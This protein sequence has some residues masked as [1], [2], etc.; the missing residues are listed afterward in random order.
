MIVCL[1]CGKLNPEGFNYCL[2]CGAELNPEQAHSQESN[3]LMGLSADTP[4]RVP[5]SANEPPM[6]LTPEKPVEPP[7][8]PLNEEPVELQPFDADDILEEVPS[9]ETLKETGETKSCMNCGATMGV[10]D[11]FCGGCGAPFGQKKQQDEGRTM[12]MSPLEMTNQKKPMGKLVSLDPSGQEGMVYNLGERT[13]LGRTKADIT[14]DDDIYISPLHCTME[15]KGGELHI[16]DEASTNGV[17][18][19]LTGTVPLNSRDVFRIGQQVII[20][21][22]PGDFENVERSQSNDGTVFWGAPAEN[23]WGKLMRLTTDGETADHYPLHGPYLTMGRERGDIVF[24]T[25]PFVSG[26]HAR[27]SNN[28]GMITLSDLNSSNG[29]FKKLDGDFVAPRNSI[30][31][32]GR[33][34]FR[35]EY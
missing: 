17:F 4:K 35:V 26:T 31:L 5:P 32:V 6:E 20:F 22:G 7:A 16:R 13:T 29:T 12:F 28:N 34:L 24:P 10:A 14:I 18:A 15:F 27:I 19:R 33:R 2:E 3:L 30:V 21:V 8:V 25:D 23:I 11:R 1:N 9:Q